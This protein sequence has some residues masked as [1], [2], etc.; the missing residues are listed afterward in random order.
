MENDVEKLRRSTT[1]NIS[2]AL[3]IE[4]KQNWTDREE[5][6]K[7]QHFGR[8]TGS[9]KDISRTEKTDTQQQLEELKELKEANAEA[10]AETIREKDVEQGKT[11]EEGDMDV[12]EAGPE[13]S[14]KGGELDLGRQ[15]QAKVDEHG[16]PTTAVKQKGYEMEADKR[17]R[18]LGQ[19]KNDVHPHRGGRK[20]QQRQQFKVPT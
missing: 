6:K 17:K 14:L 11:L 16:K 12:E 13:E 15:A 19:K 18:H 8:R 20:T 2:L 7:H 10:E 1:D 4:P 5:E 9:C 3:Q